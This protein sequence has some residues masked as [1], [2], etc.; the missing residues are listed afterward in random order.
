MA[1]TSKCSTP[2]VPDNDISASQD[3][4]KNLF[5]LQ[6]VLGNNKIF[7][8][9]LKSIIQWLYSLCVRV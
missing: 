7:D 5:K 2:R 8:K 9:E 6:N 1:H 3:K 4:T